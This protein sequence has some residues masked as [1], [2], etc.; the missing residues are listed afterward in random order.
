MGD[1]QLIV[2]AL[3]KP[4]FSMDLSLV[5]FDEK[6][7]FELLKTLNDVMAHLDKRH[8]VD[9]RDE[10]SEQTGARMTEF[11]RVLKFP[12]PTMP[13]QMQQF[14]IGLLQ[15]NRNTIYPLLQYLLSNLQKLEKRAYLAKYLVNIEVPQQFM[16]NPDV[17]SVYQQYKQMRQEFAEHHTTVDRLRQSS[18]APG[19]LR[20]EIVQ[21]EEEN[22]SLSTKLTSSRGRPRDARFRLC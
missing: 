8:N 18:L 20:K 10:S 6:S 16:L 2:D 21:L 22:T 14:N 7:P 17:A 11:L 13:E 19:E 12:L 5:L 3:N 4:P 9:I 15:G 1:I